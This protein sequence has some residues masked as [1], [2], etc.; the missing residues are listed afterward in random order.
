MANKKFMKG[1]TM[2]ESKEYIS[3]KEKLSIRKQCNLV[4]ISRSSVYHYLVG[5][6]DEDL[7]IMRLKDEHHMELPRHGISQM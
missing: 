2:S 5:E 1:G 3:R 4:G 6:N 7:R